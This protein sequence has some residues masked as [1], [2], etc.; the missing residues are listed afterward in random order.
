MF[1]ARKECPLYTRSD[2]RGLKKVQLLQLATDYEVEV[3]E[4]ILRADLA[5]LLIGALDLDDVWE[6]QA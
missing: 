6:V 4:N 5:T 1:L 2:F 3:P